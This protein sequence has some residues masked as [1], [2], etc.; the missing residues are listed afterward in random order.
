MEFK[1]DRDSRYSLEILDSKFNMYE[2]QIDQL[3]DFIY[4]SQD[5]TKTLFTIKERLEKRIDTIEKKYDLQLNSPLNA[6]L[7]ELKVCIQ[8]Y[9][10]LEVENKKRMENCECYQFQLFICQLFIIGYLIYIR[11]V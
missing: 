9:Y 7:N 11:F 3:F 4:R 5:D 2:R 1:M 6:Q 8:N 10:Y